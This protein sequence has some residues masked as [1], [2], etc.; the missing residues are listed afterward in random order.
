[1]LVG[2]GLPSAG[3]GTEAEV[4][5]P[6]RGNCLG[7][8]RNILRLRV[9]QLTCGSLNGIRIRQSWPQSYRPRTGMQVPW[10]VQRLGAGVQGLWS[11]P[12]ATAATDCRETDRGDV[13][14]EI[15]VGNACGEKPGSHGS[16]AILLSHT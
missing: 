7:Q 4:Q 14:E 15:V 16:K 2:L 12:R 9:K 8:R 10:K 3:G 13:R 6:H 1:M 5:T 11:N